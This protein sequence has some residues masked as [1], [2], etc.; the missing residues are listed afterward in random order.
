MIFLMLYC[1][2]VINDTD[3]TCITLLASMKGAPQNSNNPKIAINIAGVIDTRKSCSPVLLTP[4]MHAFP[5]S[6]VPVRH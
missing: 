3:E 2:I 4:V 5:V 6:L 1:F